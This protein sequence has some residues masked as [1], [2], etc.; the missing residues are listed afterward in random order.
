MP[1]SATEINTRWILA[2][3]D[4]TIGQLLA[5]LPNER[6]ARISYYLVLPTGSDSYIVVQWLEV[7][8]IAAWMG[9]DIRG[10]R[11]QDLLALSHSIVAVEQASLD[12]Q[13]ARALRDAHPARRLLVLS[14]GEVAGLL[15][16][17]AS[18]AEQLPPDPFAP[19]APQRPVVLGVE[20]EDAPAAAEP[21]SEQ[22]VEPSQAS[23]DNR[24]ING[25]IAELG[26]GEPLQLGAIYELR[27]DVDVPRTDAR[28]QV[29]GVRSLVEQ[30]T[31]DQELLEILVVIEAGDFTLYGLDQQVIVVPRTGRSKNTA[32]F[33]IEPKKE[34]AGTLN[35]IFYVNNRVFQKVTLTL[36]V[37]SLTDISKTITARATGIAF[38]SALALPPR[39]HGQPVNV[40]IIKKEEGYQFIVQGGGVARALLRITEA[41][42]ADWIKYAREQLKAIIYKMVDNR[43]VYQDEDTNIPPEIH[44]EALRQLG[45][46]GFALYDGLFYGANGP[47]AQAMGQL[48]SELSRKRQLD[49]Q[50]A[51]DRFF[52]PW[53][54][55]YDGESPDNVDPKGLWGFKHVIEYTPEFS[56]PSPVSFDPN[57]AAGDTL[58]IGFVCNNAI[59]TQFGRPIL[60]GQREFLNGLPGVSVRDYPSVTDLI[61]L[62][63]DEQAPPL[64]YMYCHAVSKFPNED[65]GV[66]DST[67]GLTD[68]KISLRELKLKA[69]TR[70]PILQRAPLIYLNACQSAELSPYLYDGLVPYLIARGARGVLGTEADTPALFAAEF[71]REFLKRFIAGE[72]PL[73]ELL[74]DLRSEY[75]EQKH[76]VLG[77]VYALYS[78][79]DVV[80]RRAS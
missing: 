37:G 42:I 64:I 41:Q 11:I 51:G 76:N 23:A 72:K 68:G 36:Q 58:D 47:D 48:L 18:T 62:L 67:L 78:S 66:D 73:G 34:G 77:L 9:Q 49:I 65:G 59:D 69:S 10:R 17:E 57:I 33:A 31:L 61:A 4:A 2:S 70:R 1:I 52:F 54:M 8:Q 19:T 63:L 56:Q 43:Y 28:V 55:L 5:R 35:A 16:V 15:S 50:I 27:F 7:E 46:V 80:V 13:E 79:G 30:L 14:N 22:P 12:D 38:P 26:R 25:W 53:A 44:A 74:L 24:V 6:T 75:L 29:S 60:A 21:T 32:V 71:A 45:Q 39:E 3:Q 40:M 20:A